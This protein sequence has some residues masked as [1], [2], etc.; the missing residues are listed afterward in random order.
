MPQADLDELRQQ[1]RDLTSRISRLEESLAL[2]SALLPMPEAE[3]PALAEDPDILP[4][5]P[6]TTSVLPVL[7]ASLLGLAGAYLIRAI[8]ESGVLPPRVAFMLG[9]LYA[10]AW[11]L[12]AARAP[13]DRRLATTAYS[14]TSVLILSPLLWESTLRFHM[15]TTWE[16]ST[17]L[18]AFTVLGLA[19]SWR[20]NRLIVATLSTLAGLATAGALLIASHD[21]LPFTFAFLAIAAAVEVC[22]CLNHWLGERWLAAGA[23]NLSV[24]LATWLV[25]NSQGL[26]EVYAAIPAAALFAAQIALLAIYLSSVIVRTLLRGLTFTNF[27]TAQCAVA[28]LIG[29]GGAMRLSSGDAR[30][31]PALGGFALLCGAACY[32]ISFILLE[33]HGQHGRNFYT[34]STFGILLVVVGCRILSNDG[35][36]AIVWSIL[37]VVCIGAGG[38]WQRLTLEVHG[39][40]YLVLALALSGALSQAAGFLLGTAPWPGSAHAVLWIGA[41]VTG[42]C[43]VLAA[44]SA[45]SLD[46]GWDIRAFRLALAAVLVWEV[47]GLLAGGLTGIYQMLFNADA[48]DPYCVTLR[49]G[50][51]TIAA[52]ILALAGTL[53]SLRDLV[54][55]VYPLMLLGAFRLLAD[56][57]HHDRKP[58]L[59]LSMLLYGAALMAIPRLRRT[60]ERA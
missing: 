9:T 23:A 30:V 45:L 15:V 10:V 60:K 21:V 19:V 40:I 7:G 8:A 16:A 26:P 31:I 47:L 51:I 27:E 50:A 57:M 3:P 58:A 11:L 13:E 35:A 42:A 48:S 39:G 49:T 34:Y 6:D 43:Y 41:G 12:G 46:S 22:A 36:A 25:T 18:I 52:L 55:M 20:K 29:V 24:L 4:Q 1:V 56:D 44:R 37:A 5:V 59:V 54:Q 14:L 33:R 17:I 38:L 32:A 53:P 2:R 28:F